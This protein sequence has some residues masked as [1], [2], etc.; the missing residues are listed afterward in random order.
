MSKGKLYRQAVADMLQ[1]GK[2]PPLFGVWVDA[3][4]RNTDC[5]MAGTIT[6]RIDSSNNYFV[7]VLE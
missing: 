3:Y 1:N 5:N 7:T 6:T 4:N 2:I